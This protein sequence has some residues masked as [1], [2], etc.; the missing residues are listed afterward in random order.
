MKTFPSCFLV[1]EPFIDDIFFLTFAVHHAQE[2]TYCKSSYLNF[3][4]T[5]T[6]L[7]DFVH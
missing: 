7:H 4:T 1:N 6:K 2:I 5:S 3:P